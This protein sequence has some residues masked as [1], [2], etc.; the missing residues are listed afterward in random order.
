MLDKDILLKA[1][2]NKDKRVKTTYNLDPT[3][4][5]TMEAEAKQEGV[6]SSDILNYLLMERY[7]KQ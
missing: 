5:K 6:N 1:L 2:T 7:K 3:L 4:K